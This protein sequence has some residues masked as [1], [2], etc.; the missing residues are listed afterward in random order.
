[1]EVKFEEGID[2]PND[3]FK[4]LETGKGEGSY[5][6][7]IYNS[8]FYPRA[9]AEIMEI[10]FTPTKREE[11]NRLIEELKEVDASLIKSAES[12]VEGIMNMYR[13]EVT[14]IKAVFA[15]E[16]EKDLDKFMVNVVC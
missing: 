1:M 6:R 9:A 5:E 12:A 11:L 13:N 8:N 15:K 16:S 10:I 2:S 14:D 3:L 4:F 7:C